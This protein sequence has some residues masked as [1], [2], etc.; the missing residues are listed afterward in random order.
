[1]EVEAIDLCEAAKSV[2]DSQWMILQLSISDQMT[3][4]RT[5]LGKKF[6]FTFGPLGNAEFASSD[7]EDYNY[8]TRRCGG[9]EQ[10]SEL[11]CGSS[12]LDWNFKVS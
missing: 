7:H 11:G 6:P 3:D 10:N 12:K 2:V 8:I 4:R 5:L 9:A 1:M